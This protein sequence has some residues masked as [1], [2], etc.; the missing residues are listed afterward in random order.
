MLRESASEKSGVGG[1]STPWKFSTAHDML[2]AMKR[3]RKRASSISSITLGTSV[4]LL[5]SV[6][7]LGCDEEKQPPPVMEN[8]QEEPEP[9]PFPKSKPTLSVDEGGPQ[10]RGM[11][12][13]LVQANGAPDNQGLEKLRSYLADEKEFL[14]EQELSLQV[15]RQAKPAFV[16]TFLS[17]LSKFAPQKITIETETRGDLPGKITVLPQENAL[18]AD[19]CTLIGTITEDR[20]TAIW[21]LS[22][23]TARKRGRGMGGPDLSM[24]GETISDMAKSCDSELFFVTGVEGVEWG[25]VYDLAAAALSLEK[26]GLKKAVLPVNEATAGNPLNL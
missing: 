5:L 24:T 15:V 21:R 2:A 17:E 12:V 10:V 7:L 13:T 4:A 8:K 6:G 16:A 11:G 26:A 14:A 19:K 25:L 22:G 23:G 20:G 3:G 18:K 1:P 9:P